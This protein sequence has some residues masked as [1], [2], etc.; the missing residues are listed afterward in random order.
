MDE[1]FLKFKKTVWLHILIKCI[2][3]GAAAGLTPTK[4]VVKVFLKK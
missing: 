1:N 3:A 2:A 4:K